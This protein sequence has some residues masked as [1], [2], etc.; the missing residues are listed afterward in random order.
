MPIVKNDW[1]FA[2][3]KG[4]QELEMMIENRETNLFRNRKVPRETLPFDNI[5]GLSIK[6][7]QKKFDH[8]EENIIKAILEKEEM[9]DKPLELVTK[10]LK[11]YVKDLH[12][13]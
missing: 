6:R 13:L 3:V 11:G 1:I 9:E 7:Q 12:L 8:F 4:L 5:L 2:T 10:S